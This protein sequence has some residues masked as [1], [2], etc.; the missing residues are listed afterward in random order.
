MPDWPSTLYWHTSSVITST[1]QNSL[2]GDWVQFQSLSLVTA[3]AWPAANRALYIPFVVETHVTAYK[4]AFIVGAQ[5]GNY[6]VGLYDVLGNRLVSLGSTAVPAAGLAV[7]DIADTV[8]APGVY[9]MAMNVSTVTT[10]TVNRTAAITAL[11]Q[12]VCGVKQQAVGAVTL[13]D[14][15]TFAN[16]A[17]AFIP[18]LAVALKSTI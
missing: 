7:A 1:G 8:L 15:A 6:D 12:I 14:P 3:G 13:P 5:A 4:M 9:Y 2:V 11:S 10:L 17:S 18:A 16:P